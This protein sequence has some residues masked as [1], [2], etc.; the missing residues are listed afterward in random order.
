[1]DGHRCYHHSMVTRNPKIV[2]V[3]S[4]PLKIDNESGIGAVPDNRRVDY[5]GVRV[6][7][8]PSVF[9]GL[10]YKLKD[11]PRS[12]DFIKKSIRSGAGFGAPFLVIDIPEEWEH[13]DV[14]TAAQVAGH[15]GRNRMLATLEVYGDDPVEVHLFFNGGLRARDIRTEW[16]DRMRSG[17]V[18]QQHGPY[19]SGDRSLTETAGPLFELRTQ[20]ETQ[21]TPNGGKM[22]HVRAAFDRAF[23][24]VERTFPDFGTV[25][26]HLDEAAGNDNGAGSERQF[27]F[28]R[29]SKPIQIA[30][31]EK[32]ERL[33]RPY[34]DGL[35]RHEFG[36][37]IEFR[38]GRKDL[39]KR[40][41]KLPN[42]IERRADKIAEHVFGDR[43]EY[44]DLDIQCIAC[45]GKQVRPGRLG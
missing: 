42:S 6:F 3:V 27:G 10:A 41:G 30:F 43:I 34:I 25:E 23:D 40:W 17:L 21:I 13:G 14:S 44:G 15:E 4:N 36:H 8:R 24:V 22:P 12:V 18:S 38:Y 39:E 37:A 2:G 26:L 11:G 45:G 7:M 28:C 31:A 35:M 9:L 32:T 33:P 29:D 20:A 5:L 1:M 19:G 16:V